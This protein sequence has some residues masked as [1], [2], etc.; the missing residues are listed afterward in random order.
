MQHE[1]RIL[2]DKNASLNRELDGNQTKYMN[3]QDEIARLNRQLND[4]QRDVSQNRQIDQLN[5]EIKLLQ[6]DKQQLRR[7]LDAAQANTKGGGVSAAE[8][9]ETTKRLKKR[10]LECQ[11]LWDTLK[12]LRV[13]GKNIFD[14]SEV[15][16]VLSKR[17]LD[18]KANRKLGL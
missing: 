11:A 12:D 16:K 15:L 8:F 6:Q 18:T 7:Q 3:L 5:H 17:A 9:A 4:R 13:T 2:R 1:V 14:V 10:E